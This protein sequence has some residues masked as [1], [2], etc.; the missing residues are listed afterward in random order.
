MTVNP[1]VT[2]D[3]S[4]VFGVDTEVPPAP[5]KP[6]TKG[7]KEHKGGGVKAL[8]STQLHSSAQDREEQ[9][10]NIMELRPKHV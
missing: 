1:G 4:F 7:T 2:N 5:E 10:A 6:T 9:T 3:K 8:F